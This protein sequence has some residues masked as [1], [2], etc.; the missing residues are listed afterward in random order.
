MFRQTKTRLAISYAALF[1]LILSAL[2]AAIYVFVQNHLLSKVDEV[3]TEQI[4]VDSPIGGS[5]SISAQGVEALPTEGTVSVPTILPIAAIKPAAIVMDPRIFLVYK[6][7]NGALLTS[8]ANNM[9]LEPDTLDAMLAEADER[10]LSTVRVGGH[11][12]RISALP[13][14][15]PVMPAA[16]FQMNATKIKTDILSG[17]S[18][19]I[20]GTNTP[21][22]TSFSG[23]GA[24][25]VA[26][27]T[28][29]YAVMSID[30]E[31]NMLRSLLMVLAIAGGVGCILVVLAGYYMAGRAL[32]PIRN[33][34]ER[35]QQFVADASHELR[36]PLAVMGANAE[37][38]L[39]HPDHTIE[40]ESHVIAPILKEIRRLSKLV[41]QLLTL[42]RSDSNQLE[43]H[44]VP[45]L[46]NEQWAE[47]AETFRPLCEMKSISLETDLQ[48]PLPFHGDEERL[49]QLL[50]ILLDNAVKHTPSGGTIRVA[51]SR[52]GSL[53]RCMV[54]DTGRGIPPQDLPR[55]FDRFFRGDKARSR[56][57]GGTGLGL[58]IAQWIVE[59]HG[60]TIQASSVLG[61]GTVMT[62]QFP[63][64]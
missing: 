38:L 18:A 26:E 21:S 31:M 44:R 49:R 30:S 56:T 51:C 5:V 53:I 9:E 6:S 48:A 54:S 20:N 1:L 62:I 46:L 23:T 57:D 37:M 58:T 12:Y 34:W 41:T 43:L 24:V 25:A 22:I 42:A 3:L 7:T 27:V 10:S 39:R 63:A 36:T 55:I 19:S 45:L 64:K 61:Q 29:S 47:S 2:G 8:I 17:T 14:Q 16:S 59:K 33:A 52:T 11:S 4:R 50:V 15:L 40:Q 13:V 60:G 28:S 35:Q 32:V